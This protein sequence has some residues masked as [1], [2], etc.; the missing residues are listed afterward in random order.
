MER[1]LRHSITLRVFVPFV[2]TILLAAHTFAGELGELQVT[3]LTGSA[4]SSFVVR[5]PQA[6]V[7]IVQSTVN[8]LSFECNMGI[9]KV[10]NPIAGEYRIHLFAGT[11]LVTFKAE[12]YLPLRERFFLEPKTA[13]AYKVSAKPKGSAEDR[14]ELKLFYQL[15]RPGEKIG[16]SLDGKILN[17]DFS[18]GYVLLRPE[19]GSRSVK[20]VRMGSVWEKTYELER[21]QK[22]EDTVR[23][24]ETLA[25]IPQTD[26]RPGAL[27]ITSTVPSAKVYLND[28]YQGM[29]PLTLDSV[30][31]G[32]YDMRLEKALYQPALSTIEVKSKDYSAHEVRLAPN[33]GMLR[34]N[35]TP[36]GALVQ[37]EGVQ[38][39]T[40]PYDQQRID[41]GSYQLH[42]TRP[43]YTER[44]T[45]I[46]VN[47]GDSL[48]L[49][50]ALQPKFG[51]LKITSEPSG[52]KLMLDGQAV[53]NTPYLADTVS[54]GEHLL[55]LTAPH[56]FDLD[57]RLTLADGDSVIKLL[58]L[59]ANFGKLSILGTPVGANISMEGEEK[60]LR[61]MPLAEE[62]L[63]PGIY[64]VNVTKDGY[65]AYDDVVVME[66]NQSDTLAVTLR[67]MTGELQVSSTPQGA[68]IYI[69]GEFAGVTPTFLHEVP[70]GKRLL[71]LDKS[72]FDLLEDSLD[73][74]CKE[75]S[76]VNR[77]LSAA[78]T[79]VWQRTRL[80][81][82]LIS[83]V[84]PGL[85]EVTVHKAVRGSL[86]FGAIAATAWLAN[87]A[88]REHN[89]QKQ[90]YNQERQAYSTP[91]PSPDIPAHLQ[92]QNSA[93][94][95]MVNADHRWLL[96]IGVGIGLYALQ[97][98]DAWLYG[99]GRRP[100]VS[101]RPLEIGLAP[102]AHADGV[103][104][105]CSLSGDWL[106]AR[107]VVR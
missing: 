34:I 44:D 3:P 69:D 93:Y 51:R 9:I 13:Q 79:M 49:N 58:T 35:T 88:K 27:Y 59:S 99:A 101:G 84:V 95:A 63:T 17:L 40:T 65:E 19:A 53:G 60:L 55:T 92:R 80:K 87:D 47:I 77:T 30:P 33:F 75:L 5:E 94:D 16:G 96:Y 28:V 26:V 23:F 86:W 24:A 107:R 41:A 8:P 43:Y 32:N 36:P 38:R 42:V 90:I 64:K 48:A 71:R 74:K 52:A 83:V 81:E 31:P 68:S 1:T 12:G 85:G 61:Q 73:V 89:T 25:G 11:S 72:G 100:S 21:T 67:R 104:M 15:V 37:I 46:Q 62:W 10:D 56:Y 54:S 97:V 45:L 4:A 66:R 2:A 76:P 14:P 106:S 50:W 91:D 70:T 57:E 78:G 82:T 39:G 102:S 103:L 105:R 22:V 18:N 20:L 29:T 7:L 98:T 6:A